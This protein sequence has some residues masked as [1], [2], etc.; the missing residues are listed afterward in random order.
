M[1]DKLLTAEKLDEAEAEVERLHGCCQ[2]SLARI[3]E[4]QDERRRQRHR[5]ELA[6]ERL[7]YREA[8]RDAALAEV[9]RLR[10]EAALTAE[11][12]LHGVVAC[13]AC[14]QCLVL[15]VQE[16]DAALAREGALRAEAEVAFRAAKAAEEGDEE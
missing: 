10:G 14:P 5:A 2:S 1:S 15:A 7:G 8:E 11:C 9:E 13:T 4:L 16:R 12:S 3:E 6:E